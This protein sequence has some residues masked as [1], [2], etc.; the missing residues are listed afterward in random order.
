MTPNFM[1]IDEG[2]GTM[3]K[4]NLNKVNTIFECE[5]IKNLFEFILLI[6]H[7]EELKEMIPNHIKIHN[8]KIIN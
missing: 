4:K 2:F 8:F 3:D 6:T 5:K 7:K 1:I